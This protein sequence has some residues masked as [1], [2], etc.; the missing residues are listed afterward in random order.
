MVGCGFY[1]SDATKN[2]CSKCYKDYLVKA[3]DCETKNKSFYL[4]KSSSSSC[5]SQRKGSTIDD[6]ISLSV[7]DSNTTDEKN[8]REMQELQEEDWVIGISIEH[9]AKLRLHVVDARRRNNPSGDGSERED[10]VV[11]AVQRV[12][13]DGTADVDR[14][15]QMCIVFCIGTELEGKL[16]SLES[17]SMAKCSESLKRS[18][19]SVVLDSGNE[20]MVR[21]GFQLIKIQER[22]LQI[23]GLEKDRESFD[24]FG[25]K[26]KSPENEDF[27]HLNDFSLDDLN[28][29]LLERVLSWLP[30]SS[31]FR[32]T[33]VCKRWKSAAASVSFKLACSQKP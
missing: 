17:S 32:H 13:D 20:D 4:E 9:R 18:S 30:T 12:T 21:D 3:N 15:L 10:G 11:E 22:A 26:R 19:G 31:F 24:L 29:D 33:S 8:G 23:Q 5:T 7:T 6:I 16:E 14:L 1:G 27:L 28:E 2:L 25:W